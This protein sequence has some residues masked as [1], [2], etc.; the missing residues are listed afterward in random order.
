MKT[1]N[2]ILAAATGMTLAGSALAAD[3]FGDS[4]WSD[5]VANRQAAS[6]QSAPARQPS[7]PDRISGKAHP[8]TGADFDHEALAISRSLERGD[9]PITIEGAA[10]S[11]D[12]GVAG[13]AGAVMGSDGRLKDTGS[14]QFD[15]YVERVNHRLRL[16]VPAFDFQ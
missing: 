1:R 11:Q 5:F 10:A 2:F 6:D 9:L 15:G 14:A 3:S 16:D 13:S 7:L 4:M 12:A 8:I